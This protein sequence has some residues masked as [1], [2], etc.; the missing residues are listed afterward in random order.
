MARA[1]KE[2]DQPA[3]PFGDVPEHVRRGLL[4]A[5]QAHHGFS[6]ELTEDI[7]R[8]TGLPQAE[9]VTLAVHE[10]LTQA[11]RLAMI[12]ALDLQKRKPSRAKWMRGAGY[13]F[14]REL[15]LQMGMRQRHGAELAAMIDAQ[16]K[17]DTK[18]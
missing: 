10:M 18:Q 5:L 12:G 17:Q 4:L 16:G 14:D 9:A 15:R 13:H 2:K 8:A 3:S 1:R 11:A 7:M 6:A